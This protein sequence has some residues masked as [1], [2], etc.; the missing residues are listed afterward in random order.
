MVWTKEKQ[1]LYNIEYRKKNKEKK[2]KEDAEYREN[3]KEELKLKHQEY[4]KTPQGKKTIMINCW[5]QRGLIGDEDKIYEQY[6]NSNNCEECGC[7]YSIR[8]DGIGR[9]KCMDHSH[10]TGEFRNVLCHRCNCIRG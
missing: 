2:K 5:R 1:R 10:T 8:G 7:E 4:L 3:H 9:F 6:L